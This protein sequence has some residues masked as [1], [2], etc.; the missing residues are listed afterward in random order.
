MKTA[1]PPTT[2]RAPATPAIVPVL[3]PPPVSARLPLGDGEGEL[4]SATAA[5]LEVAGAGAVLVGAG[6]VVVGTGVAGGAAGAAQSSFGTVTVSSPTAT[7]WPRLVRVTCT[8]YVVP[9]VQS[10]PVNVT[11]TPLLLPT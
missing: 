7:S 11:S 3:L 10:R 4:V 5:A 8:V 2:T 1:P 9:W 6:E